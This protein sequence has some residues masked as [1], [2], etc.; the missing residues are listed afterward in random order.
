MEITSNRITATPRSKYHKYG[1]ASSNN[2]SNSSGS[3]NIDVSNFVKKTGETEQ[4]IEGNVL[5]TGDIIAYST[6]Q[7]VENYP[8]A[9]DTA[10][11]MIKVGENLTITED[12]TLNAEAGGVSNWNELQGKPTLLTDTNIKKWDDNSHTHLNKAI[13]DTITADSIHTHSNK[14]YLDSIDQNLSKTSDVNF[15][16]VK[17]TG[18][19]IAYSTGQSTE[20]YP[21]ASNTALGTVKVGKNLTIDADGTLNAEAGGVTSWNEL[22]D[23]PT[24]LAGYGIT[25]AAK[26]S[27]LTSHTGNT[28]VHITASERTNWNDANSKKHTHTNKTVLDGISSTNV[29]NWNTAYSNAH[30]HSNKTTLDGIS[31]T[32]VSNWNTAYNNAHSHSNK[33]Y[34]D[35]INQNLST[36]SAVKHSSVTCT[37][38]VIAYSTGTASAPF[39]Y[40][41]PSVSSDGVLSWTNSTSEAVPDSVNIK[42]A[43]PTIKCANGSDIATN[44]TPSVTASTSGTTTTF[45]FHQLK[46]ATGAT[47]TIKCAN[48]TDISSVGEPSVTASTS[49]DTTTF[50]FHKLKGA[51]GATGQGLTYQWNGTQVRFGTVNNGSTSWGSY[52][53]LKGATGPSWNGGNVTANTYFKAGVYIQDQSWPFVLLKDS[54]TG[55]S[56]LAVNRNSVFSFCYGSTS[57]RKAYVDTSGNFKTDSDIRIKDKIDDVTNILPMLDK[58]NV[59]R[60]KFKDETEEDRINIGVS[61]Q[62]VNQCLPELVDSTENRGYNDLL[63]LNYTSLNTVFAIG[64]LKELYQL[65]KDQQSKIDELESR[66]SELETNK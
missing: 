18:D 65:V 26:A 25:D 47:P 5:A 23:K 4:T 24:T 60:F 46:G 51:T 6:G 10:L 61:A 58:L 45:T 8:I 14:S 20:N 31:S 55:T 64:G 42:G 1:I 35:N 30:S 48:G 15:G 59:F 34:L 66:I 54:S 7:S 28:T 22:K 9:S 44:G 41:K 21:I 13:L 52:V 39:K 56:W 11:G 40:W 50:T 37:G 53:D 29:S 49:G 19:I 3:A 2:I 63:S 36:T 12:G 57:T 17:A 16:S 32:N 43:T 33:T 38:D 27:D 62:D